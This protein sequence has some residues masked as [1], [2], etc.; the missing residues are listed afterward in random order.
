LEMNP[1]HYRKQPAAHGPE[2]RSCTRYSDGYCKKYETLVQPQMQC[3]SYDSIFL[4]GD[5]QF[6]EP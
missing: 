5:R 6:A 2:C 1:P 4:M 3:D